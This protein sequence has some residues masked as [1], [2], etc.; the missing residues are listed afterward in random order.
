MGCQACGEQRQGGQRQFSDWERVCRSLS[1]ERSGEEEEE[2][3]LSQS[4]SFSCALSP[5]TCCVAEIFPT[6]CIILHLMGTSK[7]GSA[8]GAGN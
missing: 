5:T 7:S 3:S 4:S 2:S 8:H 1:A 6:D